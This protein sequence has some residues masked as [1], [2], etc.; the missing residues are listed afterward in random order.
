MDDFADK[1]SGQRWFKGKQQRN[2]NQT[3]SDY[4]SSSDRHSNTG[5]SYDDR[6]S[7]S[8]DRPG[9]TGDK[10][11]ETLFLF[12]GLDEINDETES[13]DKLKVWI[14]EWRLPLMEVTRP[15]LY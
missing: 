1:I 2:T 9:D 8:N 15:L 5:S 3:E 6:R 4:S 12:G 7:G 10:A 11:G 13:V 14:N